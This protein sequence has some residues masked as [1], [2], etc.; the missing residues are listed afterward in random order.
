MLWLLLPA[1]GLGTEQGDVSN[2]AQGRAQAG[3][4]GAGR[5]W[6]L[7][8]GWET[9]L[10]RCSRHGE[11]HNSLRGDEEGRH[12]AVGEIKGFGGSSTLQWGKAGWCHASWGTWAPRR[13]HR[14]PAH[15]VLLQLVLLQQL[16]QF[17]QLCPADVG[18]CAALAEGLQKGLEGQLVGQE[19]LYLCL[20]DGQGEWKEPPPSIQDSSSG[21]GIWEGME[22]LHGPGKEGTTA[23]GSWLTHL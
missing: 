6:L 14:V 2:E 15:L 21:P 7:S 5:C 3:S 19:L 20:W 8:Q 18:A 17:L 23:Q 22:T 11:G 9:V 16:L 1:A 10:G 13:A 12:K 4:F